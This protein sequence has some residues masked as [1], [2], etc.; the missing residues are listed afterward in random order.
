MFSFIYARINGWVNTGGAG[1]LR[2]HRAHYD[3]IVIQYMC[4]E[5]S[6]PCSKRYQSFQ[7][8]TWSVWFLKTYRILIIR[9]NKSC[10]EHF[11]RSFTIPLR[12]QSASCELF[13]F[14][15]DWFLNALVFVSTLITV[16]VENFHKM[17]QTPRFFNLAHASSHNRNNPKHNQTVYIFLSYVVYVSD[18]CHRTDACSTYWSII[19]G[20]AILSVPFDIIAVHIVMC[21]NSLSPQPK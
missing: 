12:M 20:N 17:L 2:R 7:A 14:C 21:C 18:E 19:E 11:F 15:M 10:F 16:I 8:R 6:G 3:V 9:L 5:R 4:Y 1:D 13:L